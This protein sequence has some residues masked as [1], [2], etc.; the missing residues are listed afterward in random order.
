MTVKMRTLWVIFCSSAAVYVLPHDMIMLEPEM[1]NTITPSRSLASS[2]GLAL[3]V[4]VFEAQKTPF[5]MQGHELT[6]FAWGG[7]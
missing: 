5:T 6:N 1:T 2:F 4:L 3:R 7:S